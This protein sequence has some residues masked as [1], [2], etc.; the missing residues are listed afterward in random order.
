MLIKGAKGFMTD[1]VQDYIAYNTG[2]IM[3]AGFIWLDRYPWLL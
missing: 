3:I 1:S 2:T